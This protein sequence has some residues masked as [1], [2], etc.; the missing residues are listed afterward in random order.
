MV[1]SQPASSLHNRESSASTVFVR[2]TYRESSRV[3]RLD[4]R[5]SR[6]SRIE[7][8]LTIGRY[9]SFNHAQNKHVKMIS[10]ER[11]SNKCK[12]KVAKELL[13]AHFQ[14]S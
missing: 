8:Q 9:C 14:Y 13:I 7:C 6:E 11:S 10:A 2:I 5:F 3:S 4:P 12:N 1:F